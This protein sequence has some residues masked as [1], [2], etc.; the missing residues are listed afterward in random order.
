M[1]SQGIFCP[2]RDCPAEGQVDQGNIRVHSQK[3]NCQVVLVL[4]VSGFLTAGE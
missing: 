1:N 4:L 2:N 3:R